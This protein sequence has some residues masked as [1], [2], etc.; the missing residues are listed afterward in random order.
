M[1][2]GP[3]VCHRRLVVSVCRGRYGGVTRCGDGVGGARTGIW[4]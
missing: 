2:A 4:F 1:N 3:S